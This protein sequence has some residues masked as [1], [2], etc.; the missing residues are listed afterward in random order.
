MPK[1][2]PDFALQIADSPFLG[3]MLEYLDIAGRQRQY[4]YIC[5]SNK[6]AW[7]VILQRDAATNQL[8]NCWDLFPRN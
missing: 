7:F 4:I 5:V 1:L 6:Y 8:R 3:H 2:R